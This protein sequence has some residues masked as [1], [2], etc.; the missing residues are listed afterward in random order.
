LP[1]TNPAHRPPWIT[2]GLLFACLYRWNRRGIAVCTA[3]GPGRLSGTAA[4]RAGHHRST[5]RSGRARDRSGCSRRCSLRRSRRSCRPALIALTPSQRTRPSI[6]PRLPSVPSIRLISGLSVP[7]ASR[8]DVLDVMPSSSAEISSVQR[9]ADDVAPFV[10]AVANERAERLLGDDLGQNDV[11]RRILEGRTRRREAGGVRGVDVAGTG[12]VL[13]LG[14][15]VRLDRNRLIA[16]VVRGEEVGE[17]QLG[18]GAGLDADGRA[19]EFHGGR[20]AEIARNHE[21]LTVV[22]VHAHEFEREVDVTREGPG[23]VPGQHVDFARC[24]RGE[25]GLASGRLTNSTAI[26]SPKMAAATARH[27]ATSKPSHSPLALGAAKPVRPVVTP[28]FSDPR[29][30]TSAS[31][32]PDAMPAA[33][34]ATASEPRNT[35]FFIFTSSCWT[36]HASSSDTTAGRW[37]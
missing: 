21:A 36:A 29:S 22:V 9:P 17:V 23:G 12:K 5:A 18:R 2:L 11:C 30:C 4:R 24:E 3:P 8:C 37:I 33:I 27:T 25:T 10:V 16:H 28:Q 31:V 34:V 14:L 1:F 35:D 7:S 32:W 19:V 13:L 26:G 6:S 15:G 20:H